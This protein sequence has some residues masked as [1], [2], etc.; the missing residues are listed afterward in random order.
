MP[1]PRDIDALAALIGDKTYL[2]GDR[3]CGADA[4]VFA[5][6]TSILTPPLDGALQAAMRSHANLVAY[7]DWLTR[8][9]FP[10]LAGR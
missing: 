7:R 4:F 10:E 2:M 5:I 3:P 1:R 8:Q 9:F 6:V